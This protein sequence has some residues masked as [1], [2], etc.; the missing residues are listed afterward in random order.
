MTDRE[1]TL[2][3]IF[4]QM[5][6]ATIHAYFTDQTLFTSKV[7]FT[8]CGSL[9]L[10]AVYILWQFTSCGSLHLVA[11]YILWQFTSC[12]SLHLVAVYILWQFTSCGS[13][14]LGTVYYVEQRIVRTAV[15]LRCHVYI[16]K[17]RSYIAR[18]P[19]LVSVQ[20][21]RVSSPCE[22]PVVASVQSL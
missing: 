2:Q 5:F 14:Y 17:V 13:L 9:H 10:V 19:V 21:L 11:V 16:E 3:A 7:Q 4:Y 12:G 18:C 15:G 8:S 1:I 20:F 22:C 6:C